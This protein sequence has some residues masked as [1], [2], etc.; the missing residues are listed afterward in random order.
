[1]N[2]TTLRHP[3]F[4]HQPQL[5]SMQHRHVVPDLGCDDLLLE[6]RQQPLRLIQDET[7]ICD[8]AEVAGP[9]DFSMTSTLRPSPSA[10]IF[11]NLKI[12]ATRSPSSKTDL[13]RP[14]WRGGALV[15]GYTAVV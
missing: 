5:A 6:H 1:M 4:D 13:R 7:Q 14:V 10:P 3:G 8:I 2:G 11:T 15:H 9:V 12:Q